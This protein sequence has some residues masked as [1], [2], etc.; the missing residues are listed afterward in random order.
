MVR[1]FIP[2]PTHPWSSSDA[3]DHATLP[4]PQMC[5]FAQARGKQRAWESAHTHTPTYA[6]LEKAT[7]ELPLVGRNTGISRCAFPMET[8][9][10]HNAT[11][12]LNQ[13]TLHQPWLLP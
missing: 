7:Q 11:R 12:L 10:S 8:R 5:S 1:S 6:G 2:S 9:H 4:C 13:A 3:I